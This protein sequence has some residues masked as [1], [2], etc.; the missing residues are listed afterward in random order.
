MSAI[1]EG[2]RDLVAGVVQLHQ[3]RKSLEQRLESFAGLDVSDGVSALW[4][5]ELFRGRKETRKDDHE[6]TE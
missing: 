2:F 5:K 4:T 6:K 3:R 1:L